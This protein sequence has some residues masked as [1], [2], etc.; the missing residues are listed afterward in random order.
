MTI[1]EIALAALALL[2]AGIVKGVTGIG[3][4]TTALPLLALSI[5]LKTGMPLVLL[6]SISSNILVMRDAGGFREAAGRFWPIYVAVLPGLMLG[7]L[8]LPEVD[9]HLAA[10]VLGG[11]LAAY[12]GFMLVRGPW[13]MPERMASLAKGPV[14]LATGFFNGL[15][16]SQ[17]MPL[18]PY[19]LSA[20]LTPA[21]FIQASNISFTMSSLVMLVGLARIG[22][23]GWWELGL[24]L[25]GILPALL[26]VAVGNVLRR[27]LAAETIRTLVLGALVAMGFALILKAVA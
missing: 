8:V 27:R 18:V 5:G 4:S 16:G 24:S 19:L 22:L 11:V 12:A 10:A 9:D 2:A 6:P 13:T 14:G 20:G 25:A 17:V 15:T 7:L 21:L 23:L 3:Y 26:G 1:G